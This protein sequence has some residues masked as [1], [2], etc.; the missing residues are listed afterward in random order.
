[1]R[2]L[3]ALG[4]AA[5]LLAVP[6]AAEA[7]CSDL[8]AEWQRRVPDRAKSRAVNRE[9]E[10]ANEANKRRNERACRYHMEN[11]YG[12]LRGRSAWDAPAYRRWPEPR[13]PYDDDRFRWGPRYDDRFGWYGHRWGGYD[14]R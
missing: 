1:M 10:L 6:A 11:A 12:L 5:A 4:L 9:V 3:A 2:L 13:H 7:R 8:L 14:G